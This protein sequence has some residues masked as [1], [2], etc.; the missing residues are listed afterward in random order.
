MWWAVAKMKRLWLQDWLQSHRD[1]Q[2][3]SNR[4]INYPSVSQIYSHKRKGN[5]QW[6]CH[7]QINL[8]FFV[9]LLVP[10]LM[11]RIL[12]E[13][14]IH[15]I[16]FTF[17]CIDFSVF[18]IF[19]LLFLAGEVDSQKKR[20]PRRRKWLGCNSASETESQPAARNRHVFCPVPEIYRISYNHMPV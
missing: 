17:H 4:R 20:L 8:F 11:K 13:N 16:S 14:L 1:E 18:I 15:E 19:S 3:L 10:Q 12:A 5:L 9:F 6:R 7:T 2:R